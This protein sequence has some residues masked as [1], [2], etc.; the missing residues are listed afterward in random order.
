M[1][2][3][4]FIVIIELISSFIR[5]ITLGVRLGANLTAGH[6]ILGLLRVRYLG[7]L[8]LFLLEIVVAIVQAYVF[9]LLAYLYFLE[10]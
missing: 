1:I 9:T 2:L 7:Q 5:P 6:L 4:N 3:I 10:S 8:P